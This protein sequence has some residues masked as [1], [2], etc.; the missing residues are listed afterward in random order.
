MAV[1]AREAAKMLQMPQHKLICG[2]Q[3]FARRATL[4]TMLTCLPE[5]LCSWNY[6]ITGQ[7]HLA[8]L[9]LEWLGEQGRVILDGAPLEVRKHGMFSGCWTLDDPRQGTTLITAEKPDALSR[10]FQIQTPQPRDFELRAENPFGRTF[11]L[12]ARQTELARFEPEHLFTRRA[13]IRH[14]PEV[15]FPVLVFSFWLVVLCWRRAAS[16]NNS[17][18]T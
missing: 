8:R 9:E 18:A 5:G 3:F 2:W 7:D 12:H 4:N 10:R 15:E 17:A 11:T 1:T 14:R 16:R 13:R 6:R